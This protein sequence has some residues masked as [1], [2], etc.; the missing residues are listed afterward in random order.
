MSATQHSG[1]S[2]SA[3]SGMPG[4]FA[5]PTGVA[6]TMPSAA[7]AAASEVR[8]RPRPG[9]RRRTDRKPR[10]PARPPDRP[11]MSAD[12]QR[13]DAA[14]QQGMGHRSAGAAGAQQQ[15]LPRCAPAMPAAKTLL[16][17]PHVGVVADAPAVPQHD[18]VD[19][20]EHL[21]RLGEL[22]EERNDLLLVGK[23]DV[24][25]VEAEMLGKGD[26]VGQGGAPSRPCDRCRAGGRCRRAPGRGLPP[27]AW[28]ACAKAGCRAR[29]GRPVCGATGGRSPSSRQSWR[30]PTSANTILPDHSNPA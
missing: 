26:E 19:R 29:A 14:V 2:R 1:R 27:R 23:G 7:T 21:G 18:G 11:A 22:I 13:V 20:A 3:A 30:R 28:P 12:Q 4:S 25:A 15:H 6:L 5:M 8:R 24:E 16:E 9:A 17:T 10:R